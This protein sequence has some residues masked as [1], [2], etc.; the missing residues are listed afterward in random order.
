MLGL[1]VILVVEKP[2]EL[3]LIASVAEKL[4]VRP[5]IGVRVKLSARGSGHW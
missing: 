2:T 1:Q 4:G 5:R 3:Q